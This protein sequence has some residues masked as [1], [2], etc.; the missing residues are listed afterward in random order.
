VGKEYQ[1][2][3]RVAFSAL[4]MKLM[5]QYSKQHNHYDSP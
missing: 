5:V 2:L 4:A 1:R 3:C